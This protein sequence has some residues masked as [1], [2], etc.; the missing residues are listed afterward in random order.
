MIKITISRN[1]MLA[2]SSIIPTKDVHN[3]YF[4]FGAECTEENQALLDQHLQDAKT[5]YRK[6]YGKSNMGG[7]IPEFTL[8]TLLLWQDMRFNDPISYPET[9]CIPGVQSFLMCLFVVM[10]RANPDKDLEIITVSEYMVRMSQL[11]VTSGELSVDDIEI[12]DMSTEGLTPENISF[13]IPDE[14]TIV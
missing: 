14:F 1:G 10:Q 5:L 4:L 11:L 7:V 3:P 6:V 12:F 13:Q 8:R 2:G 9:A